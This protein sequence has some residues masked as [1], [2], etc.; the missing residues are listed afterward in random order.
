M[1]PCPQNLCTGGD[2]VWCLAS[3][4]QDFGYGIDTGKLN[5]IFATHCAYSGNCDIDWKAVESVGAVRFVGTQELHYNQA[6]TNLF[7]RYVL[8]ALV[9]TAGNRP[10]LVTSCDGLGNYRV[11]DP[12]NQRVIVNQLEVST[13]ITFA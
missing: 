11:R 2:A 12:R 6:C 7:H 3:A 8:I 4:L 9:R 5:R 10:V 13:F 1:S